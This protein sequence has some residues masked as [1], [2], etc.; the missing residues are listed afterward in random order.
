[1]NFKKEENNNS[2]KSEINKT[3]GTQNKKN[4]QKLAWFLAEIIP[5]ATSKREVSTSPRHNFVVK[6]DISTMKPPT[7]YDNALGTQTL[8]V[9]MLLMI[10]PPINYI[11]VIKI[12]SV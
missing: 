12:L 3:R 5:I 4:C 1:M 8:D 7:S 2:N 11:H 9:D 10:L 6:Q